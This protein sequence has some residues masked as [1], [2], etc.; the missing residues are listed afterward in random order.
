M[1]HN[2]QVKNLEN[3]IAELEKENLLLQEKVVFLTQKLYGR[4]TEQTSSLGLEGQMSLFDEAET[5]ADPSASEPD[6]DDAV[7]YRRKK[8]KGQKEELLKDLPHEKK[9]CTL[10]EE[11]R[12][13]ETCGTPLLSVGE[14]FVRTEIE[15]I[16]A[17]IRIIDYYRETFECR[18]CRKEGKEYMEKSPMPYPVLQHSYASPGAVAWVIHQKYELAIPLYR[19]EKEWEALGVSL[20]RAT[21]S[22]WILT[23]YRDWL[24]PVVA[25]LHKKLLEQE[26]LHIDE[27]PVQV[28]NEPARKNTTDSYMWVY[29]SIKGARNPIR[30]FVYQPGRS[31]KY[32]Q[33]HLEGYHGFIH[34]DAYKGYEKVTCITRCICWSHLRRYFVE[35]LPKDI[36]RPD[37]TLPATAIKYINQLFE[38]ENK[39]EVLS[40]EGR[41][42]QR[43][44]QEKPVLDAF[45]SWVEE[46]AMKVLPSSKLGKAFTY[47]A[48]QKAGL[49]NYL[50]DGNCSIS[51]NLA[52]NS[53]RPFTIGRKNWLFSG[54][55]RGAEASA[56]IYSLIETAKANGLNPMKY[57]QFILG[58]IPGTSF[59]EYPEY[60]EEY[61]PW[62]PLIQKLCR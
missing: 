57:I 25:L 45:W 2:D 41:K 33:S 11:D 7:S 19:Q 5:T 10:A 48:N 46:S 28:M 52:E 3:R 32:P 8:H 47:A 55:P 43:L 62:D 44:I 26:Y 58:D 49:M 36:D 53:I 54:S 22:N 39:L 59:L 13:C 20:S 50:L 60:L 17:K 24:S 51:N 61:M 42:E 23:S 29:C 6:L 4:T 56:G 15:F 27:T 30:Q 18:K 40:S 35:A 21:M 31:G 9:L 12:F 14:E 38:I 16:P 37:A 1:G 34:T